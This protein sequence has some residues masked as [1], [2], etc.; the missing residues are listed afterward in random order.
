MTPSVG[1]GTKPFYSLRLL[2]KDGKKL[3][4][5]DSIDNRQEVRWVAAQLEKFVGLK[6]DTHVA[7]DAGMGFYG[8][9]PQ[10]GPAPSGLPL[11]FRRNSPARIAVGIAFFLAWIGFIGYRF[12]SATHRPPAPHVSL[13]G[14]QRPG[15]HQVFGAAGGVRATHGPGSRA[16]AI[17][18]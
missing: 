3:T 2:T 18:P 8:P 13:T 10:R 16:S 12:V 1:Q 11:S 9:P 15:E 5:A 17:T 14:T 6:L 7:I 4:L